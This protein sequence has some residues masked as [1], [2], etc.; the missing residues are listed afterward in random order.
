[1]NITLAALVLLYIHVITGSISMVSTSARIAFITFFTIALV[2]Y[3]YHQIIRRVQLKNSAYSVIENRIENKSTHSL[4]LR[5][6]K[7]K[8]LD[9]QPGQFALIRVRN[10]QITPEPHPFTIASSPTQDHLE[11]VIKSSGDYTSQ[12]DRIQAGDKVWVDGP[13]G[14]F[15]HHHYPTEENL[16]FIAGGIGITPFLSMLRSLQVEEPDK[17]VILLWGCR[18]QDDLILPEVFQQLEA[19]MPNFKWYPV[20][21]DEPEFTG[22]TGFFN[23][24]K[25]NRLAVNEVNLETT[26]FYTCGPGIM[27][28]IVDEALQELGVEKSRIHYEKFAF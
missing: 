5:P 27:M 2:F 15:S 16:V 3:V 19:N 10:Q 6:I 20:L 18:F 9:Y 7:G 1:M 26:G 4:H 8:G 13:F 28:K 12:L 25:L 23:A 22:E 21:S 14:V 24:E 11:F 17:K